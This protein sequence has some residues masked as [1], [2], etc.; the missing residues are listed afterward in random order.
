MCMCVELVLNIIIW[1]H[2]VCA[3]KLSQYTHSS[4]SRLCIWGSVPR[5]FAWRFTFCNRGVH[6]NASTFFSHS[7][8]II[9]W[10]WYRHRCYIAADC[11]RACIHKCI[12][13]SACFH[14]RSCVSVCVCVLLIRKTRLAR[15]STAACCLSVL[16]LHAPHSAVAVVVASVYGI[17]R[18][19]LAQ[20]ECT[21]Y[22][23]SRR[24]RRRHRRCE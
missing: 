2:N 21:C 22:A 20:C 9:C 7:T 3:K 14:R 18:T 16:V 15:R 5:V 4:V 17:G 12:Q 6:K 8:C 11:V 19:V 10:S 13:H 23:T 24:R 1:I